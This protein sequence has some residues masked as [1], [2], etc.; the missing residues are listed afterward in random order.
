MVHFLILSVYHIIFR[1]SWTH[2][3]YRYVTLSLSLPLSIS[4]SLHTH[5]HTHTHI[6]IYIYIWLKYVEK[7]IN[8]TLTT[9]SVFWFGLVWWHMNHW[10]LFNSIPFLY[11]KLVLFQTLPFSISTQFKYQK[12]FYFKQF[13]LSIVF[14]VTPLY[15]KSTQFKQSVDFKCQNSSISNN[16]VLHKHTDYFYLTHTYDTIRY[17]LFGPECIWERWHW[18]STP[19]SPTLQYYW[20]LNIKLFSTISRILLVGF[21]PSAEM[22]SVYSATPPTGPA[23]TKI[24]RAKLI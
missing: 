20:C 1:I 13:N 16:S 2:H 3:A 14:F 15:V 8:Q 5:T 10:K 18:R 23:F 12:Q 22:Q 24:I 9:G 19:H 7:W 11:I 21:Y 4:L 6:Y 17:F